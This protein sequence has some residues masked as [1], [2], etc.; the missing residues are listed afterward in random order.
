MVMLMLRDF[1]TDILTIYSCCSGSKDQV[2]A[3]HKIFLCTSIIEINGYYIRKC[4]QRY[5]SLE[6]GNSDRSVV[7]RA[8]NCFILIMSE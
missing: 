6:S 5:L 7:S 1:S 8:M 3:S 2:M 4:F